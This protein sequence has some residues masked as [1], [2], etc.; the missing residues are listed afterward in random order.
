MLASDEFPLLAAAVPASLCIQTLLSSRTLVFSL[1][2]GVGFAA[3]RTF[4]K[5]QRAKK[6]LCGPA[7][8]STR[9]ALM[10]LLFRVNYSSC[11]IVQPAIITHALV[12][13]IIVSAVLSF[14]VAF[15]FA[16][17][18]FHL[19]IV[20][21]AITIIQTES[22]QLKVERHHGLQIIESRMQIESKSCAWYYWS[23]RDM[24]SVIGSS[25]YLLL[26][27]YSCDRGAEYALYAHA[28]HPRTRVH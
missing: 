28:H 15:V 8:T 10:L 12:I 2:E 17:I 25:A 14:F 3:L 16:V 19:A 18:A 9:I 21:A 11:S 27:F 23:L 20:F 7:S 26:K 24:N 22:S 6:R 5:H 4:R 1:D 13:Q